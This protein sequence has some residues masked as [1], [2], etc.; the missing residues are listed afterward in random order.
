M[1][2]HLKSIAV[3]AEV[4]RAGQFRAAADRLKM[5]PSA[6]SYHVRAL[7]EAIGTPLLYRSTRRF[8]LTTGGA[9][10]FAFAETMMQA[11][12]TGFAAAQQYQ[13]GLSGQLKVT[14]SAALSNSFISE[15]I[16]QFS[17]ENPDVDLHLHYENR[18]SDLVGEGIDIALR[19][20]KLRDSILLCRHLWD[21]PR[22]LIASP[23]F[24]REYGPFVRPEDLHSIPWIRFSGME[25]TRTLVDAN[26]GQSHVKQAG[27]LSVNSIEAMIDLTLN[28]AGVSSPP[29]HLVGQKIDAGQLVALIPDFRVI[30]LPVYAIWH[31]ATVP[32]M[33]VKRF[34][35]L[36]GQ[37]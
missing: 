8:T 5:T 28:G 11:A 25:T 16:A 4:V 22:T 12:E 3:F 32:N 26:G 35:D 23:E 18:E 9:Q 1:I 10:L 30:D 20:G 15:R 29:S 36:I 13:N 6:V 34:V 14:L 17:K 21:M 2:E 7:E 27:N 33:L 31:R 24:V 37:A 19:I